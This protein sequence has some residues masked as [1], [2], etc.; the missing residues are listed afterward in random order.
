MANL[1]KE[2]QKKRAVEA[3]G[4]ARLTSDSI[5]MERFG[6]SAAS[7]IGGLPAIEKN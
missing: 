5:N 3:F 7:G 2:D 1:A 6:V 4:D